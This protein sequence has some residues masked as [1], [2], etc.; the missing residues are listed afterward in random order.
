[1]IMWR[2]LASR[3]SAGLARASCS[4]ASVRVLS[5]LGCANPTSVHA[6]AI[7]TSRKRR[8]RSGSGQWGGM[9]VDVELVGRDQC[10][11]V[12]GA[13]AAHLLDQIAQ[14]QS[15]LLLNHRQDGLRDLLANRRSLNAQ[16]VVIQETQI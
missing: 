9:E 15:W 8:T 1:M 10:V 5:T 4:Y 2:R 6:R 12:V 7:S 16:V 13:R 14:R 3:K 11:D